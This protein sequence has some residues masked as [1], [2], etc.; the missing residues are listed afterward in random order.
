MYNDSSEEWSGIYIYRYNSGDILN[1]TIYNNNYHGIRVNDYG[2]QNIDFSG[3]SIYGHFYDGYHET[4]KPSDYESYRER[5][6]WMIDHIKGNGCKVINVVK[7]EKMKS[8][9]DS[10]TFRDLRDLLA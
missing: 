9:I 3:N 10:I 6:S 2:A 7:D 8:P 1:N 4:A 5:A